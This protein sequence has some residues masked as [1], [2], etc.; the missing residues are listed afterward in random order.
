V[1]IF[2]AYRMSKTALNA[3]TR[4][5]AAALKNTGIV[6]NC[7]SPGWV[8]TS[9]GAEVI[10]KEI[11]P[12]KAL[13]ASMDGHNVMPMAKAAPLADF[14]ITTTGRSRAVRMEHI[15]KME[16][17]AILANAAPNLK[18]HGVSFDEAIS[19][20][21][22]PLAATFDDPGHSSGERRLLTIGYSSR[23]RL[24]IVCHTERRGSVRLISARRA[25]KGEKRRHEGKEPH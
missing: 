8:K 15:E 1:S 23:D 7:V 14:L 5:L 2:P 4:M 21:F 11:D 20:F 6:A 16:N 25:T 17:G 22:D 19:I 3:E 9:M 13:E 18:K 12:W 24:I 10:V